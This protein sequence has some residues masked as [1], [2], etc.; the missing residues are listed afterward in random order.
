MPPN[1]GRKPPEPAGPHRKPKRGVARGREH[2]DPQEMKQLVAAAAKLGR[3]GARDALMIQTAYRHGFRVAELISLRRDQVNTAAGV[4]HV[5]RVKH[6]LPNIHPM[7]AAEIRELNK[8]IKAGPDSPYVFTTE[9]G[10]PLTRST[11]FKIVARAG[12][13][14]GLP[15]SVHPH[16]LRHSCGFKLANEGKD[17][18]AIQAWL[19]HV[20]IQHTVTYTA[21]SAERFKGFW[22]D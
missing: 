12:R 10:Q 16:M 18:R 7:T 21:M 2:L 11:F 22:K 3:N 8:I 4:M 6:G 19:G 1:R 20:N 5:S 15:L 14:A 13:V 17:T 9:R